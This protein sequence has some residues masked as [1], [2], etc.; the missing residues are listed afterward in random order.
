MRAIAHQQLH[1]KAGDAA[2]WGA[3]WRS[4]RAR[5]FRSPAQLLDTDPEAAAPAASRPPS[6]RRYAASPR[7]ALDGVVPSRAEALG[8]PDETLVERL[9]A[10]R[11]VGRWTAEMFLIYTLQRMDILPVDDFGVREATGA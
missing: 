10:L 9:T 7:L 11:G 3:C 2:S 4:I 6:W 8:M 5:P 1:A